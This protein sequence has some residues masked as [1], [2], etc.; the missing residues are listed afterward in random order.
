MSGSGMR[1]R[2]IGLGLISAL[3]DGPRASEAA[4]R[5]GRPH[6]GRVRLFPLARGASL[7]VGEADFPDDA[8]NPLPRCHQLALH[9][10]RQ[11]LAGSGPTP[12]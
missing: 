4:L 1:V 12:D 7:P 6:L 3:G 11:A 10:A 8:A 2:V 9:A 5:A